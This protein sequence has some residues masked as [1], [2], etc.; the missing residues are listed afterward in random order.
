MTGKQNDSW[1][2]NYS[3]DTITL[4]KGSSFGSRNSEFDE[5][6]SVGSNISLTGLTDIT[7]D[8]LTGV[9]NSAVSISISAG[10]NN[11]TVTVNSQGAVTRQ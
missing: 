9:P 1:S 11:K 10:G 8:R 6:F 5:K 2:V 7:F 3:A 4:Y